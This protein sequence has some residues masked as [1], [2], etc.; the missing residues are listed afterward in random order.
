MDIVFYP[1]TMSNRHCQISLS[2]YICK[3]TNLINVKLKINF[4]LYKI[5][6][7]YLNILS[8]K[9]FN[10][11]SEYIMKVK[12]FTSVICKK[13]KKHIEETRSFEM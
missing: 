5:L 9:E 6:W 11:I 8:L 7:V 13:K 3:I 1:M 10:L 2:I 4:F 12:T